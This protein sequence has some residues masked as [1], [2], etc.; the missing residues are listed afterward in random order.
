M[1]GQAPVRTHGG[2]AWKTYVSEQTRGRRKGVFG[3]KVFDNLSVGYA[4]LSPEEKARLERIG[5]AK[6]CEHALSESGQVYTSSHAGPSP[7][8]AGAILALAGPQSVGPV[9]GGIVAAPAPD[10]RLA[11]ALTAARVESRAANRRLRSQVAEENISLQQWAQ[12]LAHFVAAAAPTPARLG[13]VDG[14]PSLVPLPTGHDDFLLV[15]WRSPVPAFARAIL[16]K[17]GEPGRR[18]GADGAKLPHSDF[19]ANLRSFWEGRHCLH[20]HSALPLL[21]HVRPTPRTKSLCRFA[22]KC[23]C[24]GQG[25]QLA[26]FTN[27]FVAALR[28]FM[29]SGKREKGTA[30]ALTTPLDLSRPKPP[31]SV[32]IDRHCTQASLRPEM[33]TF[34]PQLFVG[35]VFPA[36][37]SCRIRLD[38]F[39]P[40]PP[41]IR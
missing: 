39:P 30:G 22:G 25:L 20:R 27:A 5:E 35:L 4:A 40:P 36:D 33:Q 1:L 8:V 37:L 12:G 41:Q 29:Q 24:E 32:N 13:K 34:L 16:S 21:G 3:A 9:G 19:H 17:C 38:R 18:L 14:D 2:G 11:S 28:T 26:E 10:R 15:E 31:D 6:R 23:I 7:A